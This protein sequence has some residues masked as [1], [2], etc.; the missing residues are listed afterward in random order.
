LLEKHGFEPDKPPETWNDLEAMAAVIQRGERSGGNKDFW[1]YVWQGKPSEP[2]TCNAFEWQVSHGGGILIDMNK[3]IDI[4]EEQFAAALERVKGWIG[5][6]SPPDILGHEEPQ[7]FDIW[8]KRNAAFMRNWPYAYKASEGKDIDLERDIGVTLL[9][10]DSRNT[11]HAATLGGWQ[12]MVNAASSGKER[13]A[14]IRFVRYMTRHDVQ[15]SLAVDNGKLPSLVK[16]YDDP[17]VK[18]TLP[19]ITTPQMRNLFM[20][21]D[22]DDALALRPSRAAGDKYPKVSAIYREQV[23]AVLSGAKTAG[24]GVSYLK[25]RLYEIMLGTP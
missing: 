20:G 18:S 4:R 14:A 7:T 1:G 2:L 5:K 21:S 17:K 8:K 12:L 16:L 9:P 13:R 11:R 24:E 19:F 10:R 15:L 3:N 25:N 23:H 22:K 6:I